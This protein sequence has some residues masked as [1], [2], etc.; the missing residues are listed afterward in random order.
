MAISLDD[1]T[2]GVGTLA[3]PTLT[4]SHTI[5]SGSNRLLIVGFCFENSNQ[6]VGVTSVTY[7]SVAVTEIDSVWGSESGPLYGNFSWL[8]YLLEDDL[9]SAGS[10]NVVITLDSNPTRT[11][12]AGVASYFD[13]GQSLIDYASNGQSSG[14]T[15]YVTVTA[16]VDESLVV[17]IGG[18]GLPDDTISG[19]DSTVVLEQI[20][21]SSSQAALIHKINQD[22]CDIDIG[23]TWSG[24]KYCSVI[25][26][27][28]SPHRPLSIY[29]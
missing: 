11:I 6:S 7:N 5:G 28:F 16:S 25:G 15:I 22:Q 8:G 12:N 18:H 2:Q 27:V 14:T 1:T 23:I 9:P 29:G 17:G 13:V 3:S 4:F 24:D 10:Y 20:L 26:A 19:Y 21:G